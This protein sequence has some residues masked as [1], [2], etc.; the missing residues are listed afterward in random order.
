LGQA[1]H[2]GCDE[3]SRLQHRIDSTGREYYR[4]LKELQRLES[5]RRSAP[6]PQ[7]QAPSPWPPA[8]GPWPPTPDPWPPAPGPRPLAPGPWPHL[9]PRPP[10]IIT[11]KR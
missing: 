6:G 8:P 10:A 5:Q 1:L 9:P 3:F 2:R 4:A 11:S 7:P